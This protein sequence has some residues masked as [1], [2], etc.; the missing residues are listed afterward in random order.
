MYT[1]TQGLTDK[2]THTHTAAWLRK[3]QQHPSKLSWPR[4]LTP[5]RG[6]L[7]YIQ[8]ISVQTTWLRHTNTPHCTQPAA[9]RTHLEQGSGP[10]FGVRAGSSMFHCNHVILILQ[11]LLA[12]NIGHQLLEEPMDASSRLQGACFNETPINPF[13]T[14]YI[15][16][17]P[18]SIQWRAVFVLSC[19]RKLA[20]K[21]QD[22]KKK[23]KKAIRRD[24][25]KDLLF[26]IRE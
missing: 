17:G 16:K 5:P 9:G 8:K 3:R 19:E 21:K 12:R 1:N 13:L 2:H 26:Q 20:K 23:K 24:E 6:L 18:I 25:L 15:L 22:K 11:V 14:K 10:P 7:G 4:R